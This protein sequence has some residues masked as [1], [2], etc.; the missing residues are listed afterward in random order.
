MKL[1]TSTQKP[2]FTLLEVL[3]ALAL[4]S[5]LMTLSWSLLS[6]FAR[7]ENRSSKAVANLE[8]A[9]SLRRQLQSDL[10]QLADL[11]LHEEP[12]S[13]NKPDIL[14]L[15][16][17]FQEENTAEG[18]PAEKLVGVFPVQPGDSSSPSGATFLLPNSHLLEGASNSISFL[19]RNDGSSK[20]F[21][22]K[23]QFLV[24]S[25]HWRDPLDNPDQLEMNPEEMDSLDSFDLE[26][27][28]GRESDS[29]ELTG[30]GP[31]DFVRSVMTYQD[32]RRQLLW[33]ESS[34]TE[35]QLKTFETLEIGRAN[36]GDN[37]A[38]QP[39]KEQVDVIHEISEI[40]FRY[41]NGK[42]WSSFWSESETAL[43]VAIEVVFQVSTE[44]KTGNT[45]QEDDE[46][47]NDFGD[48]I[49]IGEFSDPQ[50]EEEFEPSDRVG[51]DPW[52]PDF[53][54][55]SKRLLIRIGTGVRPS[56]H[57]LGKELEES[58]ELESDFEGLQ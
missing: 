40:D 32:Y 55:Q 18:I 43:P 19:I 31:G 47:G 10:D 14:S 15:D 56:S 1:H 36:R 29:E 7:L 3:I 12:D 30:P 35:K 17:S 45:N 37:L 21:A 48:E 11:S 27:E 53:D 6:T 26:T 25:Y 51:D 41:F 52:V 54:P 58:G 28:N 9:R 16:F 57:G 39:L 42:T 8:I 38:E 5:T 34:Q 50:T 24:V 44:S 13:A 49:E 22:A 33:V 2:G 23:E 46:I 4:V 20:F